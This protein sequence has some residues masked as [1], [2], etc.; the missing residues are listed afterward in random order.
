MTEVR[1][2]DVE[3]RI[4]RLRTTNTFLAIVIL[5]LLGQIAWQEMRISGLKADLQQAQRSLDAGVERMATDRL[6]NLRRE[7]MV[8]T[9]QWLDDF[10]RSADGLQRPSG[11]WRPDLNKPD[12]EAIGVWVLDVYL[13]SRLAGKPDAEAR[14]AVADQIKSTD[15]W[16]LKHPKG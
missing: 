13:Q 10:Y 15:E 3:S 4:T 8:A 11:L 6:K 7:E 2:A 14:Q 9:V 1:P 5:V 12:G 16:R